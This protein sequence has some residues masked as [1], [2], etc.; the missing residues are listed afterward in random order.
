MR[1]TTCAAHQRACCS[2]TL[3]QIRGRPASNSKRT[4]AHVDWHNRHSSTRAARRV[5][6]QQRSAHATFPQRDNCATVSDANGKEYH[7]Q[8]IHWTR[9][10]AATSAQ[11]SVIVQ[12]NEIESHVLQTN[13][14]TYVFKIQCSN[15]SYRSTAALNKNVESTLTRLCGA[16]D[17]SL[18]DDY[19]SAAPIPTN[20]HCMSLLIASSRAGS[21]HRLAT[22]TTTSKSSDATDGGQ[23]DAGCGYW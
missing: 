11:Q 18:L 21:P 17:D 9:R 15:G 20:A 22:P 19:N 1:R 16:C 12:V 8:F 10:G 6:H 4:S 14:T 23:I 3:Q 5:A 2:C 7:H 13:C